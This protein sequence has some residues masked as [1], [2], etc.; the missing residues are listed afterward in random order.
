MTLWVFY[1]LPV[2]NHADKW[3]IFVSWFNKGLQWLEAKFRHTQ[4][5]V[6]HSCLYGHSRSKPHW[7]VACPYCFVAIN[8]V[9]LTSL[10]GMF[11]KDFALAECQGQIA[12]VPFCGCFDH[13][14]LIS[15]YD[16]FSDNF[17]IQLQTLSSSRWDINSPKVTNWATTQNYVCKLHVKC[18]A[19]ARSLFWTCVK[20]ISI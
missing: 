10:A 11:K 5:M 17:G 4:I 7:W 13:Y 3:L 9:C 6:R 20:H 8:H 12:F 15:L 16:T 2:P 19:M 18:W 1:I 14:C